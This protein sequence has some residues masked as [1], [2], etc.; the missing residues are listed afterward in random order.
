MG[1]IKK[2]NRISTK[3]LPN[4]FLGPVGT[5]FLPASSAPLRCRTSKVLNLSCL[6]ETPV[7]VVNKSRGPQQKRLFA[8]SAR[9]FSTLPEPI[10]GLPCSASNHLP[11]VGRLPSEPT[12]HSFGA[13]IAHGYLHRTHLSGSWG[14]MR[15]G[16]RRVVPTLPPSPSPATSRN[17]VVL[18]MSRRTFRVMSQLPC[19]G[20][21]R[22]LDAGTERCMGTR[23]VV[24]P[25]QNRIGFHQTGSGKC[26]LWET[27][28]PGL[29]P[30][31]TRL[32][33]AFWPF[34][35]Q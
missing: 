32:Q 35:A 30:S 22:R 19:K 2:D 12:P 18:D 1:K 23:S 4:Q 20:T 21:A 10:P 34:V 28:V 29:Q 33:P 31:P 17:T 16:K 7:V 13:C 6:A 9:R 27:A 25:M 5:S 15:C 24:L 14:C 11:Q 3:I 8:S 26:S